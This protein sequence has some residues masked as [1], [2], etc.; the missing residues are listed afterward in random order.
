M[1]NI[2]S[3]NHLKKETWSQLIPTNPTCLESRRIPSLPSSPK[4]RKKER[5]EAPYQKTPTRHILNE[6]RW[7]ARSRG[8]TSSRQLF[9]KRITSAHSVIT[10]STSIAATTFV[11][12]EACP[13][14]VLRFV[15]VFEL[16]I[17]FTEIARVYRVGWHEKD[18][19][20]EEEE[21]LRMEKERERERGGGREK[22]RRNEGGS[23]A[24]RSGSN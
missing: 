14:R 1:A 11:V 9:E 16:R 13:R 4:K 5:K 20:Q 22:K 21:E 23:E 24:D 10:R 19:Q 18:E 8:T 3:N 12:L 2:S 15:A 6:T 7:M 17:W